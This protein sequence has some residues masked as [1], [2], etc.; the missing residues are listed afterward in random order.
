M[1]ALLRPWLAEPDRR[2]AGGRTPL[3]LACWHGRVEAMRML[4]AEG[5]DPC[6]GDDRGSTSLDLA[7]SATNEAQVLDVLLD[8]GVL[9]RHA[10]RAACEKRL[11]EACRWRETDIVRAL[12]R[13]GVDAN[14]E[15]EGGVAPIIAACCAG[16][17]AGQILDALL[18][19]G[20]RTDTRMGPGGEAAVGTT[21][22]MCAC[23]Y[24]G[25]HGMVKRLLAAGADPNL[26]DKDGLAALSRAGGGET[27][28]LLLDAGARV[29]EEDVA[30]HGTSVRAAI[31]A[32]QA[33]M[34]QKQILGGGAWKGSRRRT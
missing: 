15:V 12:L 27:A 3:G 28:L 18:E 25:S 5:A 29:R 19:H 13:H 10:S 11:G 9:R 4:L 8:A 23:L 24:P 34:A 32:W 22:L 16:D 21:A 20:A 30:H 31:D 17:R 7:R 14:A 1:L 26:T 6:L 33:A 2:R